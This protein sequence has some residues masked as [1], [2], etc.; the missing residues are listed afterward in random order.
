MA[1][2]FELLDEAQGQASLAGGECSACGRCCR[3]NLVDHKLYATTAELAL[4]TSLDPPSRTA[5]PGR[6]HYQKVN[7][8]LARDRRPLGCRTFFCSVKNAQERNDIHEQFHKRIR[9]LHE[10]HRLPYMYQEIIN[11]LAILFETK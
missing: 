11:S 2:L 6:C 7:L 1:E 3:F 5:P 9:K 10:A 8:C 4:L